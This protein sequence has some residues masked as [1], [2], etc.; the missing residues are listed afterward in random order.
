MLRVLHTAVTCAPSDFASCTAQVPTAPD[1]VHEHA[2][3]GLHLAGVTQ[4]LERRRAP[5]N[6]R[7]ILER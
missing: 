7:C 3:T 1:A 6:S 4:A 5:W 2:L